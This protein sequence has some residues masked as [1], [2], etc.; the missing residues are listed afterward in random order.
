MITVFKR[1]DFALCEVPVPQGYPQSQTHCTAVPC[2]D[3]VYLLTSPY[4][5]VRK[6]FVLAAIRFIIRKL[7]FGLLYKKVRGEYYENPCIYISNDTDTYPPKSFLL[8]QSRPLVES[9]DDYYGLPSFNSD[10]NLFV[11]NDQLFIINRTTYRKEAGYENRI[12]LISGHDDIG[13]FRLQTMSLFKEG[14]IPYISPC[15]IAFN[16]KYLC[17]YLDT[18]CYNDGETYNGLYMIISDTL[19]ALKNNDNWKSV[20]VS[21]NRYLPW[22]MSLFVY[23][24]KLYS[25]VTTIKRGQPQKGYLML[26]EF[27]DDLNRLIIYPTP[28]SDY[29]SYRSSAFV[30]EKGI[31]VLYN[32]TLRE[33]IKGGKSI[34]GREIVVA[35]MPFTEVMAR[36]KSVEE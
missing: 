25:I 35:Q 27:T 2:N 1:E 13:R 9:P 32:A 18:N 5:S 17:T 12:F 19:E 31:F 22:H 3:R 33:R 8:M 14:Q 26:G 28:L 21:D 29:N 23:K 11:E 7:S 10:P 16:G 15:V 34:D 6:P 30:D 24:T 36:I 4:P 20:E